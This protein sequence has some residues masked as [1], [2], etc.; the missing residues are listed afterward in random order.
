VS[1]GAGREAGGS[2]GRTAGAGGEGGTPP[3]PRPIIERIGLA[4]VAVVLAVLF[5]FVAVASW[6]GGEIF[7]AFMGALGA[8]VTVWL[9]VR[10]LLRG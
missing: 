1:G 4:A 3:E 6:S 2:D 5:A 8:G 9:A 7:L 10:T